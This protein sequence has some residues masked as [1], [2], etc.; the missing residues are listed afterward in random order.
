[1]YSLTKIYFQVWV[2]MESSPI[3]W[4]FLLHK[5]HNIYY[6]LKWKMY[7]DCH[8]VIEEPNMYWVGVIE[9]GPLREHNLHPSQIYILHLFLGRYSFQKTDIY[10]TPI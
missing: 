4:I 6:L 9:W 8:L 5:N 1:M 3:I 7:G 2:T 10:N